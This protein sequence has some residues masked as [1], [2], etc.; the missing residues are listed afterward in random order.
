ME[1]HNGRS[2][3]LPQRDTYQVPTYL[4]PYARKWN[5]NHILR[6]RGHTVP[7]RVPYGNINNKMARS[8][9]LPN[10]EPSTV[11]ILDRLLFTSMGSTYDSAMS[12]RH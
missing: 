1:R 8:L 5:G 12:Q 3:V 4:G 2:H 7:V 9:A 6:Q 11:V 10:I